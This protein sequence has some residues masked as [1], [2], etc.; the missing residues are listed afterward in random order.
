VSPPRVY[1]LVVDA[2]V[3]DAGVAQRQRHRVIPRRGVGRR[4]HGDARRL[5]ERDGVHVAPRHLGPHGGHVGVAGGL[6]RHAVECRPPP[7]LGQV[8]KEEGAAA[9]VQ[10]P[11]GLPPEL[12]GAEDD[13]VRLEVVL[14]RVVHR[15]EQLLRPRRPRAGRAEDGEQEHREPPH[16][17]PNASSARRACGTRA[18]VG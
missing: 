4:V 11:L 6:D 9:V 3:L 7:Q 17:P 12:Q 14:L 15:H 16:A 1:L 8:R 5:L 18:L 10:Q 2:R 13:A